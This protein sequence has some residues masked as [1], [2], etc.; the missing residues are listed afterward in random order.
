MWKWLGGALALVLLAVGVWKVVGQPGSSYADATSQGVQE[1][2]L[3]VPSKVVM[4]PGYGG[5]TTQLNGLGAQLDA[6]GM[7][8]EIVDV[9]D[10][11]GD[12]TRYARDVN[13]RAD[14]LRAGGYDVDL[15]GY[16]A[17]G[18]TARIAATNHPDNFRRVVTLSA[19]HQGTVLA[20]LGAAFGDCPKACQQMRPESSLLAGLVDGPDSDWLSIYSTTDEVIR[21]A[22]SS[23]LDGAETESLQQTCVD[24]TIRHGE[25]PTHEQTVAILVAFLEEQPL[26]EACLV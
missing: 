23:E 15:V 21:P 17:G 25:V 3:P 12:L 1:S 4:I 7:E 6:A 22:E 20:D 5:G 16:S 24:A 8:W 26:P 11:T 19:P 2:A 10:G 13:A 18:I 9:G 14:E